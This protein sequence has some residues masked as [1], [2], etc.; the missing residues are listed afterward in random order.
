MFRYSSAVSIAIAIASVPFEARAADMIDVGVKDA[1]QEAKNV[2]A[3]YYVGTPLAIIEDTIRGV[4]GA[5][6]QRA[7][8]STGRVSPKM[9]AEVDVTVSAGTTTRGNGFLIKPGVFA[10]SDLVCPRRGPATEDVRHVQQ[11]RDFALCANAWWTEARDQ[12]RK[13]DRVYLAGRRR[14]EEVAARINPANGRLLSAALGQR[15]NSG[16]KIGPRLRELGFHVVGKHRR[17]GRTV[18]PYIRRTA[19]K[20][21]R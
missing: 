16:D 9:A 13:R 15:T 21:R 1:L 19:T 3:R 2:A 10:A 4:E 17:G 7:A 20:P 8:R 18:G 11:G 5:S 12:P 14:G 6:R